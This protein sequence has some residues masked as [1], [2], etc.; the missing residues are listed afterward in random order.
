LPSRLPRPHRG[1]VVEQQLLAAI[2]DAHV[3]SS[4]AGG[5]PVSMV[6][7]GLVVTCRAGRC[8]DDGAPAAWCRRGEPPTSSPAA[9]ILAYPLA[10]RGACRPD[11]TSR[12][13]AT[14]ANW[15]SGVSRRTGSTPD[16]ARRER[17]HRDAVTPQRGRA[18]MRQRR[19]RG[20]LGAI[21]KGEHDTWTPAQ[22]A[23]RHRDPLRQARRQPSRRR[24]SGGC[25]GRHE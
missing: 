14:S 10:A 19:S 23:A 1:T 15:N 22:A 2:P 4:F 6:P 18:G 24:V 25:C 9:S 21:A 20:S 16:T 8:I 7:P 12:P 5:R 11:R 3:R 17:I 13:S